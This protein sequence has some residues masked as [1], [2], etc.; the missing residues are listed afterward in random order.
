MGMGETSIHCILLPLFLVNGWGWWGYSIFSIFP[1]QY[2][3]NQDTSARNLDFCVEVVPVGMIEGHPSQHQRQL[4]RPLRFISEAG[5]N[6]GEIVG[7]LK[8]FIDLVR[9]SDIWLWK[10]L[11]TNLVVEFCQKWVREG[12][13]TILSGNCRQTF[14]LIVFYFGPK[15]SV[16][17]GNQTPAHPLLALWCHHPNWKKLS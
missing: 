6:K 2:N 16:S 7:N 17:P 12:K 5:K 4:I 9:E 8:F 1:M 3:R 11:K 14:E 10:L 15:M 13:P